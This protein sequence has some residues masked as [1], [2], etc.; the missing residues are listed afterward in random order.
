MGSCDDV[1]PAMHATQFHLPVQKVHL[2]LHRGLAA[3][4]EWQVLR[5]APEHTETSLADLRSLRIR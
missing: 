4:L 3:M 2:E 1:A 5:D